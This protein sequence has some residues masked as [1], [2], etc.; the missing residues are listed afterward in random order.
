MLKAI[1]KKK[2]REFID[3]QCVDVQYL[4]SYSFTEGMAG[5]ARLYDP[6][7]EDWDEEEEYEEQC[8]QSIEKIKYDGL[9]ECTGIDDR[10]KE[11]AIKYIEGRMK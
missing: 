6:D 10:Y 2:L 3:E 8:K 7:E 11:D 9:W 5:S 1:H 4:D